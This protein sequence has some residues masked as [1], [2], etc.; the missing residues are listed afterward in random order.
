MVEIDQSKCLGADKCGKCME[1][2]PVGVFMNVPIGKFKPNT[3]PSDFEVLPYY[4]ISCYACGACVKVC[5]AKC[6]SLEKPKK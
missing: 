1:I 5:P 3:E 2:C 4:N 6:I